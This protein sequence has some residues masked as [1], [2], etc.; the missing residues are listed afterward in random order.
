FVFSTGFHA[1]WYQC[2]TSGLAENI[3][4]RFLPL[5]VDTETEQF[6]D[7]SY[8]KSDWIFTQLWHS[9]AKAFLGWFMTQ[10]SINGRFK[11]DGFFKLL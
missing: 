10:T 7:Q 5:G 2:D 3:R 9:I 8:H 11:L 1:N 4:N 6:L